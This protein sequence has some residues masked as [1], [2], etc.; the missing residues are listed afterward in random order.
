MFLGLHLHYLQIPS[1]AE[2][3]KRDPYLVWITIIGCRPPVT[4]TPGRLGR[5]F[6][7]SLASNEG[8]LGPD[9]PRLAVSPMLRSACRVVD[10]LPRVRLNDSRSIDWYS[11][12]FVF[13]TG[14]VGGHTR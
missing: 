1:E 10:L 3:A 9:L 4:I 6:L 2:S 13:N 5:D 7:S 8:V 12:W 14:R 11:A